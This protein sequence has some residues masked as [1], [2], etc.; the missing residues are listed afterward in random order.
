MTRI[1]RLV[2]LGVILLFAGFN[3]I[4]PQEQSKA[5]TTPVSHVITGEVIDAQGQA[6][7]GAQV[8]LIAIN[9]NDSQALS[10]TLT[11][12]DGWFDLSVPKN[13]PT[14]IEITIDRVH[15]K[16]VTINLD[17]STIEH[18]QNGQAL[19]LPQTTLKRQI[20]ISFW[21]AMVIFVGMLLAIGL[22]ILH[23]TLA[24]LLGA[25]LIF[26]STY[27]G[28]IFIKGLYI[29]NFASALK[30]VDWNVIFLVMGMMT[31]IAVVEGTGIFQWVAFT[32]Y[33]ISRGRLW[34]LLPI[35]MLVTGVASAFLDNVTTMLLMTPI[36]IEIALAM[37]ANPLGLLI[38]EVLTSNVIG[39]STLVGTP[40]NILIGSYARITF[41]SFLVNL[42]PG[43][44]LAYV[45]LVV[46]SEIIYRREIKEVGEGV[47]SDLLI[48]KLEERAKITQPGHLVKAGVV[49]VGMFTLFILGG[50]LNIQPAVTALMGATVLL[51]WIKP[52]I[53][54]MIEAVD[55]TTLLFFIGLFI[56]VGAIQEVGLIS[57]IA[58]AIGNVVGGNILVTMLVVTWFSAGMSMIIPNIPFAAA[59]LPI[60]SYLTV[61]VPGANSKV[62]FFC[63]AVG[64]AM[65][66]NGSLIGASANMVTAGI[67]KRAGYP[68]T[69]ARF[70]R[71]GL[72]AMVITVAI[73]LGWLLIRFLVL[74]GY[75]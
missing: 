41:T 14:G 71:R 63:L 46:Y 44:L 39:I 6:V 48:Q 35:L 67:S 31:F 68:I 29:F 58:D 32:A 66:G 72:P 25:T 57:I 7:E 70:M 30:Y 17:S 45:G 54:E 24:A 38:P 5:Q 36:S 51:V 47:S 40:T 27:I 50:S 4:V 73:T 2:A 1:W 74:K 53:E 16:T 15:F 18:L 60:I 9:A 34:L 20:N 49:G 12:T 42:T 11:Q 64:A 59:M 62:L 8:S 75:A 26:L 37:G 55:W 13:L 56:V 19:I 65:G 10:Q 43:V 52:D 22:R 69:Y 21:V 3:L 33:K 23:N 61:T 28:S